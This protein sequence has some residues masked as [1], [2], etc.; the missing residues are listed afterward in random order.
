[1][2][3]RMYLSSTQGTVGIAIYFLCGFY[4]AFICKYVHVYPGF[5]I[6]TVGIATYMYS[7]STE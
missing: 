4:I 1:M 2:Y 5:S 6:S 3:V 7:V